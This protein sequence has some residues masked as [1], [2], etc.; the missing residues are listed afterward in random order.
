MLTTS[1]LIRPRP[2]W[3]ALSLVL[4]LACPS[5]LAAQTGAATRETGGI[6]NPPST[7]MAAPPNSGGQPTGSPSGGQ[8]SGTPSGQAAATPSGQPKQYPERR[9]QP[10]R[11]AD[12]LY[13]PDSDR[14]PRR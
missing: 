6:P 3:L 9:Q 5:P 4:A 11:P 7:P 10:T 2:L 8:P 13:A 1:A 14:C 12:G